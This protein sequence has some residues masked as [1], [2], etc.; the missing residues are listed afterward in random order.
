VCELILIFAVAFGLVS[1]VHKFG[2]RP[3]RET[4]HSTNCDQWKVRDVEIG[5]N[6]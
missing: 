1:A 4:E 5:T 3:V 6:D 2:L